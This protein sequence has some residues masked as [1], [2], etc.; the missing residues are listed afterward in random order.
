VGDVC[1]NPVVGVIVCVCKVQ[2]WPVWNYVGLLGEPRPW[3]VCVCV[4]AVAHACVLSV[5]MGKVYAV[6][7]LRVCKVCHPS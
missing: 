2:V 6:K 1:K 3:C 7:C 4:C 5:R